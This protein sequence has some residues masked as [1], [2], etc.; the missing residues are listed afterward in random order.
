MK[1]I[2]RLTESDLTRLIKRV[3]MEQSAG[4]ENT[5]GMNTGVSKKISELTPKQQK[6]VSD[7][8]KWCKESPKFEQLKG[9]KDALNLLIDSF[10]YDTNSVDDGTLSD[11]LTINSISAQIK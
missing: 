10:E 3:I 1:K 5:Q 11:N 6:L 4:I 9:Q 2:I 8:I 7:F